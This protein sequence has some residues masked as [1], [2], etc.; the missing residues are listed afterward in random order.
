MQISPV[1]QATNILKDWDLSHVR[2]RLV[3]KGVYTPEEALAIETE[4][5]R[6]VA[7]CCGHATPAQPIVM[8]AKVDPFWHTHILFTRDYSAMG[9]A[10][11][12]GYL[13]HEPASPED[14][15]A[16][17]PGYNRTVELYQQNFGKPDTEVWPAF[18]QICG[19]SGCSCSGSGNN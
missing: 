9:D 14:L 18:A 19:G 13:H 15:A 11:G 8:C 6:F 12:T 17:E 16:L 3:E 2:K 10:I 1:A 4:Y 7:L 5:K